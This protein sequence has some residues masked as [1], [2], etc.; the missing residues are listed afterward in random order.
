MSDIYQEVQRLKDQVERLGSW[1]SRG[2]FKG[3]RITH[4]QDQVKAA[5]ANWV[6]MDLDTEIWDYGAPF[7]NGMHSA[8]AVGAGTVTKAIGGTTLVGVGT[9]FTTQMVVGGL[10]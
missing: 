7:S 2:Q 9:S 1:E 3:C 8:I 6:W 10:V 4:S 5:S